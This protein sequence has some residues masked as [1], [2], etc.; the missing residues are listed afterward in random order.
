MPHINVA[1][2]YL[3]VLRRFFTNNISFSSFHH[4]SLSLMLG[5]S[6][7]EILYKVQALLIIFGCSILAR[8]MFRRRLSRNQVKLSIASITMTFMA[9]FWVI[10]PQL[11]VSLPP[12]RVLRY[13]SLIN[14]LAVGFLLFSIFELKKIRLKQIAMVSIIFIYT[15]PIAGFISEMITFSSG[16]Y[17][18]EL[19]NNMY[20]VMS[21]EEIDLIDSFDEIIEWDSKIII[22]EF[23]ISRALGVEQH[24]SNI[25]WMN[26]ETWFKLP[27][28]LD[29]E[30]KWI[31]IPKDSYIVIRR[32]LFLNRQYIAY[33][34]K[35]V[36]NPPRAIKLDEAA[37]RSISQE[38]EKRN[39]IYSQDYYKILH[40]S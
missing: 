36:G 34:E 6:L 39:V 23:P 37:S 5:V 2:E 11:S 40:Y 21:V 19:K 17:P 15:F 28:F 27:Q 4:E 31:N 35:F 33:W 1:V 12:H 25:Y 22:A 10:I 13:T 24:I 9:I 8:E 3:G 26:N 14:S 38:I 30:N 16:E 32:P 20:N 29:W 7:I 18:F